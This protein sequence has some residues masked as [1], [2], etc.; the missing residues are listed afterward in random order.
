MLTAL[1]FP[2][3]F[4]LLSIA[5]I[6]ALSQSFETSIFFQ[7]FLE[8]VADRPQPIWK[9]WSSVIF[10]LFMC[11]YTLQFYSAAFNCIN[12]VVLIILFHEVWTNKSIRHFSFNSELLAIVKLCPNLYVFASWDSCESNPWDPLPP[13]TLISSFT[14]RCVLMVCVCEKG[15]E[16]ESLFQV[17][18]CSL[19]NNT[20]AFSLSVLV[21]AFF[22]CGEHGFLRH[23]QYLLN[24]IYCLI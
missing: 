6:F 13:L 2:W 20:L 19:L 10:I 9:Y 15:H 3:F 1:Q 16:G 21:I 22:N 11:Y 18:L 7:K 17:T 23:V 14:T 12:F 4:D 5:T 24:S 8:T